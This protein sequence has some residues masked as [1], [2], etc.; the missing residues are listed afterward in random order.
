MD[1]EKEL[2]KNTAIITIGKIC[3]QLITFFLLPLYTS[4]LTTEEYGVVDLLNTL[5]L[6]LVP[7]VTFQIEQAVFRYLV[8]NRNNEEQKNKIITTVIISVFLQII[9]Y[10]IVFAIVS[11]LIGNK[12][13][14]F[15]ATNVIASIISSIMLQIAR[16]LGD[17]KKYATGSF[18]TAFVTIIFNILFLVV[19]KFGAYGM[20]MATLIGNL[21]AGIYVFFTKNIYKYIKKRNFEFKLLKDLWKYSCPLI[22]N[23]I[24]WWVFN[25]SD[26]IIVTSI[27]GISMNGILAAA[28]KFSGVFITIYNIFNM[29]WTESATLHINDY[30]KEKF[31]NNTINTMLKLFSCICLGIIACM[32][33]VF[34]LI[35]NEK[36]AEAYNQIPILM[37]ASLF[38]II[39]GLLS[40][41]YVAK[42]DT[43]SIA[44]TSVISAIIN[45]VINIVLIKFIG[46]YAASIST[47]VAYLIMAVNRYIDVRKRYMK[48]EIDKRLMLTTIIAIITISIVY[49]I[50]NIYINIIALIFIIIYSYKMNIKSVK[51]IKNMVMSRVKRSRDGK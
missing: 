2:V 24:S 25:S 39:I 32:P 30:D 27:L 47:L 50:N 12:Y 22:P 14:Y 38:N 26:R 37:V 9:I 43:K 3:T 34:P 4:I 10:M 8:D 1:R 46:L 28:N 15:L 18:I 33:F 13:K 40:V 29:T 51:F 7:I 11:P 48:I 31:F 6:L 20:L 44:K 41:V 42:K 16:G 17:N 23:A 35:I 36:F 49:Y 45:I 5:V 21:T 19:F